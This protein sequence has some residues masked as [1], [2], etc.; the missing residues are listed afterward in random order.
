MRVPLPRDES[1]LF[2]MT[3]CSST[4]SDDMTFDISRG[5]YT[6][7]SLKNDSSPSRNSLARGF[8]SSTRRPVPRR[9]TK[10][11]STSPIVGDFSKASLVAAF[12]LAE[13]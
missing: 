13:R 9:Y 8:S 11:D 2:P 7:L 1:L 12:L 10:P 3:V 6:L 5:K 4:A